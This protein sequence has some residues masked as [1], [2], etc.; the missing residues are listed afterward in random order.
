MPDSALL[1]ARYLRLMRRR[2]AS[3]VGALVLPLMFTLLFFA[4]FQRPMI[5]A[6]IDYAQYLLP[7]VII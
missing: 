6:G 7:A 2:P 5:R 3:L 1:A 4:V